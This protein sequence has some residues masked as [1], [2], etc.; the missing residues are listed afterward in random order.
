V[1]ATLPRTVALAL[2]LCVAIPS[3]CRG[4]SIPPPTQAPALSAQMSTA[5]IVLTWTPVT[6]ITW[7][8][9]FRAVNGAWSPTPVA[10]VAQAGLVSSGLANGTLYTFK[11]AALNEG[12]LGPYSNEVNGTPLALPVIV[13]AIPGDHRIAL[14]WSTVGGAA[15]YE[16]YRSASD[17]GFVLLGSAVAG[18]TLVDTGL[19]NNTQYSYRVRAIS[20]TGASSFSNAVSATPVAAPQP[21]LQPPAAAPANVAAAPGNGQ[22]TLTWNPLSDASTYRIYRAV[23]SGQ[24]SLLT[25]VAAASYRDIGLTNGTAYSYRIAGHNQAGDGPASAAVTATPQAAPN[26][27]TNLNATGGTALITLSWTPVPGATSYRVYRGIA[28]KAQESTPLATGLTASAFVDTAVAD[29]T[30][31]YYRATAL[32]GS[33]ESDGSA[34]ASASTTGTAPVVDPA[35]VA[36]FRLLRQATWGPRPGDVERVRQAGADVFL[37]EQFATPP[38]AY[39]P[40]LFDQP[41]GIAQQQFLAFALN[42]QDQLRQRVT[43]ALHKIWVVSGMEVNNTGAVLAY[44]TTVQNEAFGNYREL[45]RAITLNPAMGRYLTMIN[46]R[47]Q[48]VSGVPAN[49]NYAREL[50]QLFTIG[51]ARLQPDGTPMLDSSGAPVPSY[52]EADVKAL[53]RILTGWTFGDGNPSTVP[54]KAAA[55]NWRVPMEPVARFHDV[56]AKTFLG[57]DFPAAQTAVQ[58]L[59]QALDVLFEHPNVAPFVSRQL[60]QQL[61][62]SN[63]SPG[64]VADVAAVFNGA[65]GAARG[66]IAAVVRAILTHPEANVATPQSGKLS[67][68]LLFATSVLR[69]LNA[70]VADHAILSQRLISMGQIPFYPASVFS[71]FS[72]GYKVRGTGTPPLLGPEFQI[73]TSATA[74][75]RVNF[76]ASLLSDVFGT[77]ITVDLAPYAALASDAAR[78]VD[79]C[80]VHFLG[81]AMTAGARAEIINA[82]N[83]TPPENA[84]E[85]VRTA[86]YL[87]LVTGHGQVNR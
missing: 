84:T 15:A 25:T 31:Y 53:A 87:T 30:Y 7:Y 75:E 69:A 52:T 34:E 61:V 14:T 51:T 43:W 72:P 27:P 65:T 86:L 12:G 1:F 5:Q 9:V 67:E 3:I 26:A 2:V 59:N 4:Q 11:V 58:D 28:S 50:M 38:S 35:T 54:T 79:A 24:F 42:G 16:V 70:T 77:G 80:N 18:S 21:Q 47:S 48:A 29:G 6:G 49:E 85:R 32:A 41:L 57:E 10:T 36:A 73:L 82:V 78:L 74:F 40:L 64:Y 66:D 71:Y 63:P 33:V 39:P 68:P 13:S 19:T 83:A 37:A 62:T 56:T 22:V 81:G 8:R 55:E 44:Y 60:I 20:A 23:A 76:V 46:S 45:M 17:A